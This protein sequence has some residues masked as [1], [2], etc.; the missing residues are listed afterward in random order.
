MINKKKKK[1]KRKT[2]HQSFFIENL[3]NTLKLASDRLRIIVKIDWILY[4][5][6]MLLL[7]FI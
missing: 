7:R 6:R 3:S 1:I 4:H 2:S 5:V